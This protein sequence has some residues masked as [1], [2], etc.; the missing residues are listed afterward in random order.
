MGMS[1]NTNSYRRPVVVGTTVL[2]LGGAASLALNA[3][4]ISLNPAAEF[5][6]Y[7]SGIGWPLAL[8]FAIELL[9]HTPW[10]PSKVDAWIKAAVLIIVAGVAAWISY[11]HGV[12]VL[13]HWGYDAVGA[14]VGPLVPDAAMG[15]A[16]LALRRV[17]Q[18]RALATVAIP[19]P[20]AMA[21]QEPVATEP[22]AMEEPVATPATEVDL[23]MADWATLDTDLDEELAAMTARAAAAPATEEPA[24]ETEPE[25]REEPQ[26]DASGAPAVALTT[27]PTEAAK[28]IREALEAD[29]NATAKD[30]AAVLVGAGL[31]TSDRTGRRWAAA[32]K[33]NTARVS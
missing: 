13:E 19:A 31:A 9:I 20:V 26:Q 30:L 14:H 24:A 6:A 27:V 5:G 28:R 11:W 21:T 16:T 1:E 3:K 18:A 29:P 10:Q 33:N 7:V 4:A 12:H 17:G 22:V 8:L 25:R 23:A 2:L 32:V 15:L